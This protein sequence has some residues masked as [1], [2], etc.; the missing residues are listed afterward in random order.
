MSGITASPAEAG[1][2]KR[3]ATFL[4]AGLFVLGFS[5]VFIVGWGGMAT[6]L[7]Q[8][9]YTYKTLLGQIGGAVII[10]FGL[11]TLGVLRLPWRLYQDTRPQLSGLGQ[12]GRYPASVLMGVFFAAGW[13]PCIG[14]TL[15][16]ILSLGLSGENAGQAMFLSSGYALGM[17]IPFL[18][19]GL[20]VDQASR[21]TAR[22]R[23]HM[24]TLQIVNGIFLLAIGVVLLLGKMTLISIWAQKN[25]W[26]LDLRFEGTGAP[27]Y[28]LAVGAGLLSFLSPCVLPLVPAY[29]GYLGGRSVARTS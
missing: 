22:F 25:G 6:V 1:F 12:A 13:T 4:H 26:Y 16:A 24:R 23:P 27:G 29:L 20:G 8:L 7:G 3:F 10:L 19:L 28:L 11:S 17:G 18:L 5:A 9:F 15:G 14:T 2:S 21:L